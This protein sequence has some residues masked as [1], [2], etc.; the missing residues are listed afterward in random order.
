LGFEGDF[1]FLHIKIL[2]GVSIMKKRK[3]MAALS[4]STML[5]GSVLAGCSGGEEAGGKSN[6]GGNKEKVSITLT[7]WQSNPVEQ[8]RLKEVIASF[9]EKYP[10]INVEL[11]AIAEQYMDVLKTRLIG[12][13]AGD[14]FYLDAFVA[15]SLVKQGVLEP[16]NE[17][18][19]ED[20]DIGDFEEPLLNS[21]KFDGK[22]YGFPKDYSTLALF[23]NK[24]MFEK[25]GISEPPKTWEQLREFSKKLTK[26]GVYGL[27]VAPELARLYH[28][29]ESTRGEVI[30]DN[31]ANF[32]SSKVIEALQPIVNQRLVDGTAA[33]PSE[34]GSN[35][36]GEMFGQGKAAMVLE[37]PWNIP[38]FKKAF[39]DLEYGIAE[40]P[41]VN[42]KKTTMAFTVAYVMN[43]ASEHKE[44]SWK[45]I[46]YLTGKEGMK[47]WTKGGIALPTRK[48]VAKELGYDKDKL[49]APFV[50]GASNSTVWQDGMNLPIVNT[51]FNN[52][53]TSAFLGKQPLDVAMKKGEEQAN[54]QIAN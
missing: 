54:Q 2:K 13:E 50:T 4:L 47:K 42:D 1:A 7:G 8:E 17:Y 10:N 20:F 37:G 26:D 6:S 15:P 18:V 38:Y 5:F 36:T 23:Y 3:W 30:K 34:V 49:R 9:E 31:K 21:F 53:F 12:G 33:A 25:A 14:V 46:S 16:L 35:N 51:N 11:E 41:T 29:A 19:T 44:A 40:H 27:G 32:G 48:S 45:L 22:Y 43:K 24:T 52:M 28:M 39:P